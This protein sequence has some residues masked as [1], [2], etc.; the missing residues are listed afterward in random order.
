[1]DIFDV[2]IVKFWSALVNMAC[3]YIVWRLCHSS[4]QNRKSL[5]KAFADYGLGDYEMIERMHFVPGRT[6]FLFE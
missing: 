5:R 4:P 1:M 2:E 6:L 3:N